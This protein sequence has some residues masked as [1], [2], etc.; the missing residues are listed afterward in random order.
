MRRTGYDR[1]PAAEPTG[2]LRER[3]VHG[4]RSQARRTHR[5][6][7]RPHRPQR[8]PVAATSSSGPKVQA[9]AATLAPRRSGRRAHRRR[10]AIA[11]VRMRTAK[12][13]Q[14][15]RRPSGTAGLKNCVRRSQQ[16]HWSESTGPPPELVRPFVVFHVTGATTPTLTPNEGRRC[17]ATGCVG[18]GGGS[19][20][21][22]P[23]RNGHA[24]GCR[25]SGVY[26]AASRWRR[27][28]PPSGFDSGRDVATRCRTL[29]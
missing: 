24:H 13:T 20:P 27:R 5:P 28:R 26:R 23:L 14:R 6:V 29:L 15:R 3:T 4:H 25:A 19:D 1:Y 21:G 22:E 8:G 7:G 17:P 18:V 2:D 9:A 16:E 10:P 12:L 11:S